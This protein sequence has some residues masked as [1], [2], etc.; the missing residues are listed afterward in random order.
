M[1]ESDDRQIAVYLRHMLEAA[2][3]ATSYVTEMT[4][5]AFKADKRTQQATIFNVMVLGEAAT[6][7]CTKHSDIPARFP[8]IAWNAMRGMRNQLVHGY[9]DINLDIVWNVTQTELP[10]LIDQL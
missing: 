4:L 8:D 3:Q 5:E 9:F 1:R 6:K 7:L 2:Q 10:K